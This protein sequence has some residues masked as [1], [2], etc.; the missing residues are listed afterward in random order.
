MT[1]LLGFDP[2]QRATEFICRL[3]QCG[4]CVGA[5]RPDYRWRLGLVCVGAQRPDVLEAGACVRRCP[6]ARL[7]LEAGLTYI[8]AS[9]PPRHA[10][11]LVCFAKFPHGPDPL[12]KDQVG[13][14]GLFEPSGYRNCIDP[15]GRTLFINPESYRRDPSISMLSRPEECTLR[16]LQLKRR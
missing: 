13:P 15:M 6:E 12:R 5:Q 4:A 11:R 2:L 10:A 1:R 3:M 14:G 8:G 7:S 9:K 16:C